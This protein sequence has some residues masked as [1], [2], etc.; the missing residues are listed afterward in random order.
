MTLADTELDVRCHPACSAM[1][2][3]VKQASK[4]NSRTR[5]SGSGEED[6]ESLEV[7]LRELLVKQTPHH[8]CRDNKRK[9]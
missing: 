5:R 3:M 9:S 2:R 1:S 6:S 8:I 4:K 7:R